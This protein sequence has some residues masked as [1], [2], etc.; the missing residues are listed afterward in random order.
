M[1]NYFSLLNWRIELPVPILTFLEQLMWRALF[2]NITLRHL[3]IDNSPTIIDCG[4]SR[5]ISSN[6]L[7]HPLGIH[8]HSFSLGV[9]R[10]DVAVFQA[11]FK[12]IG[13]NIFLWTTLIYRHVS[14]I[15]QI[16]MPSTWPVPSVLK[17]F[18]QKTTITVRGDLSTN[19][20]HTIF[21]KALCPALCLNPLPPWVKPC[22]SIF[23]EHRLDCSFP[24]RWVSVTF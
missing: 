18:P 10:C 11:S 8:K 2:K 12:V 24:F 20:K 23:W 5:L 16:C 6:I 19:G 15:P 13:L 3:Y 1:F 4:I 22:V 9:P 17:K 21:S 14:Y 7:Q